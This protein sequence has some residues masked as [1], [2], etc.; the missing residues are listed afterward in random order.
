MIKCQK[1]IEFHVPFLM[2]EMIVW[3]LLLALFPSVLTATS[4]YYV[5]ANDDQSCPSY[6][7]C[8]KLSH[9]LSQ[10]D[11]YFTSKTTIIFLKG[12]HSFDTSDQVQINN[13][14]NFT[15]RGQGEWPVA[16]PEETVMQ[17]T[18]IINC[19]RGRG[20][21]Q[22]YHSYGI[23]IE[24]LTV[25]NCGNKAVFGFSLV[26]QLTLRKNS[27]QNMTGYGLRVVNC[28]NVVITN[29]SYYH[30]T[31]CNITS[32][33][34]WYQHGGGVGIVY[35]QF[36]QYSNTDNTLELS[37]SNLTKCCNTLEGGGVHLLIEH[38][39]DSIKS[40]SVSFSH[41]VFLYNMAYTG[42]GLAMH[43]RSNNGLMSV[44][45][46]GC[47]F[48]QGHAKS[49]GGGLF[50]N[51][52]SNSTITI[53]NTNFVENSAK[54]VAEM[55]FHCGTSADTAMSLL[56]STIQ[57]TLSPSI[58]G[59]YIF[60]SSIQVTIS[61]TKMTFTNLHSM[62]LHLNCESPNL[63]STCTLQMSDSQIE[64]SHTVSLVLYLSYTGENIFTNCTFSN[65][66]GG[67]SVISIYKPQF[68]L[69]NT[70]INCTVAN[71]TMTGIALF[72]TTAYFI[73]RNVIQNNHHTHGAGIILS[74]PSFI[75]VDGEL[76]LRNNTAEKH[77]GGILA[78]QSVLS[79]HI[80]VK[81]PCSLRFIHN[82]SSV[83]F[84]G[85]KARQGGS[86]MYNVKLM[87]CYNIGLMHMYALLGKGR[88]VPNVGHPNETSWYFDIPN[89]FMTRLQFSNTDKLSSMSSDPVMI[90]FCNNN[91]LP[92]CSDRVKHMQTY[93]GVEIN[94]TIA[95]VGYYGGTSPG[96]VKVSARN[97]KLI[98]YYGQNETTECFQVHILLQNSSSTTA[99]V[100]MR[101]KEGLSI[102]I[103]VD[104]IPCPIGFIDFAGQCLCE[105]FLAN[106]NV[107]CNVSIT[108]YRFLRPGNSWFGYINNTQCVTGTTNC[109]FDYCNRSNVSFDIIAPD[110]QCLGNRTGILCGQ[111]Q[112]HLSIM[113]GSNHCGSC[114]NWYLFLLLIFALA[115]I[116]LVAVLMFF[117]LSV[118][119]GTINGIL[120]YA[121]M[122]KLNEAFF[123]PNG[124]IPVVSQ[125]ISWLNLDLG[126][127]VCLFD[128][129]DSYSNTWLQFAFP[130]YLFLLMG[131]I[132][133]GCRLSVRLCRLCGSHAVPAL[134]TLF[135]MSYTKVLLAVT[136]ALSMSQL[137]C[138]GSI[139]TVW[140]VDGNIEYGS[141]KHIIL[142][143]FSCGVIVIGL[144]YP[145]LVLCAPLLERYSDKCIPQHRWNPVAKFKPLLDA[146]GGP[147]KD[148]FRFWTGMTLMV[149][150]VITLTFSFTSGRLAIINACIIATVCMGNLGFWFFVNG[151]YK[152]TYLSLLEFFYLLNLF[153]L[154][155]VS[156]SIA[157]FELQDYQKAAV[158]ISVCLC[159]IV[160]CVTMVSHLMQK[161]NLKWM[162]KRLGFRNRPECISMPQVD[163]DD[164]VDT[165]LGSPPSIVYGTRRGEHQFV[166]E[167]RPSSHDGDA[168]SPVLLEREPLLFDT[169][170][171][172]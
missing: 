61:N 19:T 92:D 107:Q 148:K 30:S 170:I 88:Y 69:N 105:P 1:I 129:L 159:L 146:Y 130:S 118:S 167:F 21:F 26:R 125:F 121:N 50:F 9:Y 108:L 122:V 85:N 56:N 48:S 23:T 124:S 57:H 152:N 140:S 60:G 46:N 110:S 77:G 31:M 79:S 90:C 43:L 104:I 103:E 75:T 5:V 70:F 25:V 155:I 168:T 147:Y 134:A 82:T 138:N 27:I 62:G 65:N 156:L 34:S 157:F 51:V 22:F 74:Q 59:V 15:L 80:Y 131:G 12:Q 13:V 96:N 133:V 113:L 111:C 58:R 169:N 89:F 16:G 136:N 33:N 99:L 151:V 83:I 106:N 7:R 160:F 117:N 84:S 132:I 20:G 11:Y 100:D 161:F 67:H 91:N 162:K 3:L 29:C 41:L 47:Y 44:T 2:A 102:S 139:L 153:L 109:P 127:E 112:P 64:N 93:S 38:R 63:R 24:G 145:V 76:I 164:T 68:P 95:T 128:G 114:S 163:E 18:V 35:N 49:F 8:Y 6:Q 73:G 137:P 135:L 37:Y 141:T 54:F 40:I 94:T 97:A 45:I 126:I 123:F 71:N 39:M 10:P 66:T 53:E 158:T 101:V 42:A 4:V 78:L 55:Y 119:V 87:G 143:V 36:D 149:R 142:V 120:F 172:P 86:D 98:R 115:G 72:E 52:E 144:A 150:L 28:H 116:L 154:S 81:L 166:L 17:S 165:P 32:Y 171:N 14:H